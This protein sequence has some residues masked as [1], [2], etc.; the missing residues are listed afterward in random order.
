MRISLSTAPDTLLR[1]SGRVLRSLGEGVNGSIHKQK[2][3]GRVAAFTGL[4]GASF[5]HR[6]AQS[7]RVLLRATK[8]EADGLSFYEFDH[9]DG[10]VDMIAALKELLAEDRRRPEGEKIVFRPDHGHRM[11]DDIAYGKRTN[12]G[13]TAIGR[14]R[15]LA[16]LRGAIRALEHD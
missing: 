1:F 9:L 8:R 5:N 4:D 15:G 10:D 2:N 12:L 16:E 6:T 3:K 11:L 7:S 13:Y 14:L